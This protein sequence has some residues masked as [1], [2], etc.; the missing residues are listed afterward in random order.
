MIIQNNTTPCCIEGLLGYCIIII[1][2]IIVI[3]IVIVIVVI[4]I[5]VIVIVIIIIIDMTAIVSLIATQRCCP[6]GVWCITT[7]GVA[8]PSY[9]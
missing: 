6:A 8:N 9:Q 3:V 4:I 2:I 5:I 7:G 1:I